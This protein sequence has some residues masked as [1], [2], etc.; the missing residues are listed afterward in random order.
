MVS[1]PDHSKICHEN[2]EYE[3]V[4]DECISFLRSVTPLQA[5]FAVCI[6]RNAVFCQRGTYMK[7]HAVAVNVYLQY[8]AVFN[9][10][11]HMNFQYCTIFFT[12]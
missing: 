4:F 7:S 9:R 6:Y 8:T 3:E 11:S 2:S 1:N 12:F 5:A 10:I